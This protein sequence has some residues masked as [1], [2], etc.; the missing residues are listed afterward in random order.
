MPT[1]TN[2]LASTTAGGVSSDIAVDQGQ[3]VTVGVYAVDNGALPG[4][5]Q[6]QLLRKVG[7]A[8]LSE[9][10]EF[11]GNVM[12]TDGRQTIVLGAPGTYAVRVPPTS[13]AVTVEEWR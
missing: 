7:T 8:Y 3:L 4:N 1:Q 10:S 5:I 12:I 9:P 11:G 2:K 13:K 6:C